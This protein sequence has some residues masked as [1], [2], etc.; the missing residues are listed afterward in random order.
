MPTRKDPSIQPPEISSSELF[1]I[2]DFNLPEI[3]SPTA[4]LAAK[5]AQIDRLLEIIQ[6]LI[7]YYADAPLPSIENQLKI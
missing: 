6:T 3:L 7:I 1:I 4:Q 5:K 2:I